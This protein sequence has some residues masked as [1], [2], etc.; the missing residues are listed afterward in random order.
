MS[1]STSPFCQPFSCRPSFPST[2]KLKYIPHSSLHRTAC[3]SSFSSSSS[4]PLKNNWRF[5]CF[6]D[7]NLDYDGIPETAGDT[8]EQEPKR[9]DVKHHWPLKL[10]KAVD[11]IFSA[12][13]WTVP[14]TAKTIIQVML[15]WIASFW[16]VGSWIIP[17]L[18]HIAGLRKDTLT[19][20]GQA[21][22]SLLT[23]VAEG[24]AGIAILHRCLTPFCP[25]SPDWFKFSF[26]GKWLVDVCLGC[27]MFPL[28]NCLSQVNLNLL[29]ML[30][31]APVAA[32]NVEQS[33][34]A[35]DPVAMALYAT[36]V[37]VCA[38]IWEEIVFRGF[39]LP[40]LTSLGYLMRITT[41]TNL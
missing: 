1:T 25:L 22:Y 9:L 13:P 27:L 19:Y 39:L 23:D 31:P 3:L 4:R 32:S 34:V 5:S 11:V 38:P 15:L 33:I 14:W 40:S 8:V 16:L 36:V 17:F 30:P 24:A 10:R 28:V 21:F 26:K 2:P 12:E 6:K 41:S 37:S 18:G 35:R 7:E 20:R 29:P